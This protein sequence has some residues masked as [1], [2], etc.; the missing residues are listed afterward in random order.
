[1]ITTDEFKTKFGRALAT[2]AEESHCSRE[3]YSEDRELE[4]IVLEWTTPNQLSASI[5]LTCGDDGFAINSM[6]ERQVIRIGRISSWTTPC[7]KVLARFRDI[8]EHLDSFTH[9]P[10]W[11]PGDARVPR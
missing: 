6:L 10:L 4:S 7:S 8:R 9:S 5:V 11:S 3:F 1:M 2:F